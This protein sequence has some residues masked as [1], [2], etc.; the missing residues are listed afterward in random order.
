VGWLAKSDERDNIGQSLDELHLTPAEDAYLRSIEAKWA[1]DGR[2]LSLQYLVD[3]WTGI[4]EQVETGYRWSID[5][6]RNDLDAR[7]ILHRDVWEN[8]PDG[9]KA[10]IDALLHDLDKRF[11]AATREASKF[12]WTGMQWDRVPIIDGATYEEM[13]WIHRY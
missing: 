13:R 4:V 9:L 11:L 3:R 7:R 1:D 10:K 12:K 6:Y 8:A 5:E 2:G